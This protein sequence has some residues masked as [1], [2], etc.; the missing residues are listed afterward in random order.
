MILEEAHSA[1]YTLYPGSVKMYRTLRE[2]YWWQ[3]M[4]RDIAEFVCRCL[5]CQQIKA[6]HLKPS[7]KL[8]PFSIPQWKWKDIT[9]DFVLGL[10][11]M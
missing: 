8:N 3:S 1:L 7:G 6:E 5:V 2:N 10:P 9:M 11:R 4:K